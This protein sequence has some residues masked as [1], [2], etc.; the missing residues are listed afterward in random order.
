MI[1]GHAG[2]FCWLCC[3]GFWGIFG[4]YANILAFYADS[5]ECLRCVL[6]T[7]DGWLK[8]LDIYIDYASFLSMEDM[9]S[10]LLYSIC[11]LFKYAGYAVWFASSLC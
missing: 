2:W 7:L 11:R 5:A 10:A 9:L 4:S 6:A 8:L 1:F 3:I